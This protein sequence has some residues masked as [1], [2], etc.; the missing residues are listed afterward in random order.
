M[1]TKLEDILEVKDK[2]VI[3]VQFLN[4]TVPVGDVCFHR[5]R[6]KYGLGGGWM[7]YYYLEEHDFEELTSCFKLGVKE[8][9][10]V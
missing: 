6:I 10:D 9:K 7:D 3:A 2:H 1:D 5:M 4:C 8:E